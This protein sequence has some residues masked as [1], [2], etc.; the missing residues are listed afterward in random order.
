[1]PDGTLVQRDQGT[2]QGAVSIPLLANVFLDEVFDG[3]MTRQYPDIPFERY[4]DD[5]ICHCGSEEPARALKDALAQRFA[6]W[7]LAL[8]PHKTRIVYC[9]YANR[10]GSYPEHRFD[11]WATHFA[12]VR[13]RIVRESYSSVSHPQ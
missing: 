4:A 12:R 11:F 7:C 8:H 3:W 13:R 5:I 1:M 9:K 10:R 2:P 6:Q